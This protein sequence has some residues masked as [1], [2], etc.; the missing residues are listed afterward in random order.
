MKQKLLSIAAAALVLGGLMTI[1]A[2][3]KM[4]EGL[5]FASPAS[6]GS[7]VQDDDATKAYIARRNM[8]REIN[9]NHQAIL[10]L[11]GGDIQAVL[12]EPEMVRQDSPTIVWQYRNE[13]CVLDVFFTTAD[14]NA[15]SAP[16]VHYEM[17]S[18]KDA[19]ADQDIQKN[20]MRSLLRRG[21]PIQFTDIESFYKAL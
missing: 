19:S 6:N 14:Q 11:T 5:A 16:A 13:N 9:G 7:V 1:N 2:V 17:R 3:L 10:N 18:R 20:C 21:S 8:R 4:S 15:L 12:S